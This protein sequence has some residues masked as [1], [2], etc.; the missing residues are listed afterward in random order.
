MKQAAIGEV[1]ADMGHYF[2]NAVWRDAFKIVF[3]EGA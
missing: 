2:L 1:W 3:L